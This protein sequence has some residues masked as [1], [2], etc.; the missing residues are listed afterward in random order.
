M[1]SRDMN[2]L[3]LFYLEVQFQVKRMQSLLIQIEMLS[4]ACVFKLK[5]FGTIKAK[6]PNEVI[7]SRLNA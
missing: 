5:F 6:R 3:M 1:G 7:F 4:N 2:F